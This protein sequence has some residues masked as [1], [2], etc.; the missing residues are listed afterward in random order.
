M[1]MNSTGQTLIVNGVKILEPEALIG[2]TSYDGWV[3]FRLDTDTSPVQEHPE[4]D[5]IDTVTI[6]DTGASMYVMTWE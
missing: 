6:R 4:G 2:V 1:F 5:G 3:D